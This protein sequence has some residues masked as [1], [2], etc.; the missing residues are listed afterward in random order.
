ML[1]EEF[2]NENILVVP[3][4]MTQV[5]TFELAVKT[6]LQHFEQV[7]FCTGYILSRLDFEHAAF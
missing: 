7:G 2:L 1:A 5:E 3:L 4:D 6:V